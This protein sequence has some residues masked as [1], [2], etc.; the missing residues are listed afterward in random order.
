[1]F[2]EAAPIGVAPDGGLRPSEP[3]RISE[4]LLTILPITSIGWLAI[5]LPASHAEGL[6]DTQ[7]FEYEKSG[8]YHIGCDEYSLP[9]H[10]SEHVDFIKPGVKLSAP[11]KKRTVKRQSLPS[12]PPGGHHIWPGPPHIPAHH[13]PHWKPPGHGNGLPPDLAAC[14]VNI[15]PPCIKALYEIP[16]AKYS[17]PV[18][19]M[20][21]YETYDSF[22][23]QDIGR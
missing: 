13:W 19:V 10:L 16:D 4:A 5:D 22:S 23:Q 12:W 21:L 15:T 18:N 8:S 1:V 2:S 17:Q 6:L 7:Y 9:A 11:L 20:G 14:G 3:E